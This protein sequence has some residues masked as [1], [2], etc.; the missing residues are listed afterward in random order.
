MVRS[1]K[2]SSKQKEAIIRYKEIYDILGEDCCDRELF[3][4]AVVRYGY[5]V[6]E[7]LS[8]FG[9]D[10][11][12]SDIFDNKDIPK[13]I[14]ELDI[15]GS[16]VAALGVCGKNIGHLLTLLLEDALCGRVKNE[17]S[18]LLSSARQKINK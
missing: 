13:T 5:Y 8:I 18:G 6:R 4:T 1:H 14:P 12:F 10:I 17:K 16:D 15:S 2:L 7:Y 3:V 9:K 11:E